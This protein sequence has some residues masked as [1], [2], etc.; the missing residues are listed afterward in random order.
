MGRG[1]DMNKA[2]NFIANR[3]ILGFAVTFLT[4]IL[5]FLFASLYQKEIYLNLKI[6]IGI[7]GVTI[8]IIDKIYCKWSNSGRSD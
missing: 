8:F 3:V 4:S 1:L 7:I 2:E 6:F 5:L